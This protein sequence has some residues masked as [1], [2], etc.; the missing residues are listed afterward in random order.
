MQ[1]LDV[2]LMHSP[3]YKN[4]QLTQFPHSVKDLHFKQV[5]Y[6]FESQIYPRSGT[7]F[8]SSPNMYPLVH[9]EH[10]SFVEQESHFSEHV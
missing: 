5:F 10:V 4:I 9:V 3:L 2:Q 6:G 8:P 7:H 1:S